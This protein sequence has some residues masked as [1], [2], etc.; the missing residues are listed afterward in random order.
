MRMKRRSQTRRTDATTNTVAQ[1]THRDNSGLDIRPNG[2]VSSNNRRRG[3]GDTVAWLMG[4]LSEG[5][6][7]RAGPRVGPTPW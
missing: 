6:G 3:R 7:A 1:R 5:D 4:V 2:K